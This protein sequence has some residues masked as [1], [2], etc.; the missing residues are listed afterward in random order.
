MTLPEHPLGVLLCS[1][2]TLADD[3]ALA[4][5]YLKFCTQYVL[6]HCAQ[7]IAFFEVRGGLRV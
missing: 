7:D 6:D 4:E 1:F 2:A 5:D 3:M